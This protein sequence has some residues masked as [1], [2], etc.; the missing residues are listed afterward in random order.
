MDTTGLYWG[1]LSLFTLL[2]FDKPCSKTDPGDI[3]VEQNCSSCQFSF[4]NVRAGHGVGM[5][6]GQ[7]T[8]GMP[9]EEA[10]KMYINGGADYG[11]SLDSF[12]EQEKL[13][14]K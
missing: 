12:I 6:N 1:W 13:D 3:L 8:Y 9:M 11:I 4:G 14:G 10:D 7:D 2:C 5:D